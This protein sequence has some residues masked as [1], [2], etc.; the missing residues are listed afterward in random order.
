VHQTRD[1]GR[2]FFHRVALRRHVPLLHFA[3][4]HEVEEPFRYSRSVILRY[5][6]RRGLVLGWWRDTGREEDEAL[7][8]GLQAH[9]T[10]P[11][12]DDGH[13]RERYERPDE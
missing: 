10:T 6:P 2:L 9:T 3:D 11:L 13:I 8:A 1:L 7:L 12:D 5:W 4:T